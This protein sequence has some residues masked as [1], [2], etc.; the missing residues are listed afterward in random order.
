M[1]PSRSI[2]SDRQA[3]PRGAPAFVGRAAELEWLRG[4]LDAA[5]AGRPRVALVV[6]EPGIGKTRLLRELQGFAA[7]RSVA[8]SVG[9]GH[10]D[11]AVPF[12]PIAEAL[13]PEVHAL[14]PT[15]ARTLGL[16][17]E[18][19]RRLVRGDVASAVHSTHRPWQVDDS[20]LFLATARV[21]MEIARTKPLVLL[22]DDVH[23]F[24]QASLELFAHV[25]LGVADVAG[26][27]PLHLL[28]VAS[29]RPVEPAHRLARVL[30]RFQRD[31]IC[32]TLELPGLPEADV[33]RLVQGLGLPRPSHQLIAVVNDATQGNPL[34]VQEVIDHLRRHGALRTQGGYLTTT[35]SAGDVPLPL[36]VTTAIA[37]RLDAL[38]A[39]T[40]RL[41]TIAACLGAHIDPPV[42]AAVADTTPATVASVLE[43]AVGQ[44]LV[45]SDGQTFQFAHPLVRRTLQTSPSPAQRQKLHATIATALR[46]HDREPTPDHDLE[47]AHHLVAAGP[48]ADPNLLVA[49]ARRAGHLAFARAAWT[50]AARL[51]EAAL[52]TGEAML[53][54][55]ERGELHRLA[56]LSYFRDQDA[57]PCLVHYEHAIRAFE[58]VDDPRGLARAL[59]GHARAQFT[60]ASVPYGTLIDPTALVAV[61]DRLVDTDPVLAGFVWSEIAQVYWTARQ[62]AMARRFG[63]RALDASRRLGDELLAAEAHRALALVAG[64]E[65]QPLGA[66]SHLE[67]GLA[68]A[69]RANDLWIESQLLQRIPLVLLWH[70]RLD[71]VERVAAEAAGLTRKLH[72]WG[73]RSLSEGALVCV[74]VARGDFDAAELHA[75]HTMALLQRSSYPW[76][77]PTALP[78][79]AC[80][81]WYRGEWDD[82]ALESWRSRA[83]F[84]EP[85]PTLQF[86]IFLLRHDPRLDGGS[87]AAR[88]ALLR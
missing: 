39:E 87:G 66:L 71:D 25:V 28:I 29:M 38:D 54:A 74:A 2:G 64:Q 82:D 46:A 73:D 59:M 44:R 81:R 52:T 19:V 30:A 12:L 15:L 45:A 37:S 84:D 33:T 65:L 80:A 24:D 7:S 76:A 83:I 51:F 42:L 27:D 23:W 86:M 77:G 8:V 69:R 57:G 63:E 50:G 18:V 88:G 20:R 1:M 75:H 41:L 58:E 22:L 53:P 43:T 72:D 85:G 26:G 47:I 55:R 4:C 61:A 56:G 21:V 14:S 3:T 68:A 5:V 70:G 31:D 49:Y 60:L 17:A 34:F 40:R 67:D 48:A 32:E 79:L 13:A 9:R 36:D 10:E 11:L 35:A 6:G 62:P 78:A 16:D